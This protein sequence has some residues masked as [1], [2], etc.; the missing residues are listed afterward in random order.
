MPTIVFLVTEDWTFLSH[1]MPLA[2]AARDA[3]WRVVVAA[4][5]NG[6]R[7]ELEAAGLEFQAIPFDR[8]GMNPLRDAK[9]VWAIWRMLRGLHP[10]VLH[11]VAMKPL[12]YGHLAAFLAGVRGTVGAVAG[13]GY[14]FTGSRSHLWILRKIIT[15]A[16]SLLIKG[17]GGHLIVQNEDDQRLVLAEGLVA[18]DHL[19]L[20]PGS[21]VDIEALSATPEPVAPPVAFA[22]V[23]RMLKDK[24]IVELVEAARQVKSRGVAAVVRLVGGTDRENPSCLTEEQLRAWEAEGLVEWLGHRTDIGAIWRD[25]HVA[26]LPSYREGMPKALL[27]AEACGRPVITTDV[28][29][30][31]EAIEDG[32]QGILV[33]VRQ[34]RPLAEAM[35]RLAEDGGLRRRM[36]TAARA[37]AEARFDKR[38][39]VRDHMGLYKK[40]MAQ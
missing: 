26:V 39:V 29:G 18:A 25:A 9:T 11:C 30:C 4:R 13:F 20:I 36:G 10:D 8:G 27:E 22:C 12:L 17:R 19:L 33:P 32:V 1:R 21:G 2:E 5:D 6:R 3:G 24:G 31:R 40:V 15:T 37:R 38:M 7:A 23:C 34:S 16:L 28:E 14:L 35:I